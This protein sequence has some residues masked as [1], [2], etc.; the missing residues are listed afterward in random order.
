MLTG[1]T[2]HLH[3]DSP[4]VLMR[5]ER[6]DLFSYYDGYEQTSTSELEVLLKHA[7]ETR[8]SLEGELLR[9][10][11]NVNHS[12]PS[13][14][15]ECSD[16]LQKTA[17]NVKILG[18]LSEKETALVGAAIE[19]L[20]TNQTNR[21]SKIYQIFLSDI[22]RLCGHAVAL[23]CAASLGKQKIASL[24]AQQRVQ[25]V[26]HIKNNQSNLNFTI[27][28]DFMRP[29]QPNETTEGQIIASRGPPSRKRKQSEIFENND[30]Q[31]KDSRNAEQA[32]S[33]D[34]NEDRTAVISG[35]RKCRHQLLANTILVT[36]A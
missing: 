32:A 10:Q 4:C 3:M 18:R 24:N 15:T 5:T 2:G 30:P 23:L 34:L 1:D 6:R 19:I 28:E 16:K 21:D 12:Q 25:L 14:L 26:E 29:H 22:V 35:R 31:L 36:H 7:N 27:L 20:Q 33:K 8:Q 13:V 17:G 11:A 9:R